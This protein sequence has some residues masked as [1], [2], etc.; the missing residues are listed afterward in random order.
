MKTNSE[1]LGV[2]DFVTIA[3]LTVVE[4][5]IYFV[6]GMP[7]GSTPLSWIFCLGIQAIPLGIIFMLM[8]TKVNKKWTVLISGLLLAALLLMSLWITALCVAIA[9]VIG[10][11]IWH[12]FDRKKFT[13]MMISYSLIMLG[14]YIGAFAPLILMKEMYLA[15]L[16]TMADFYSQVFDLVSGPLFFVALAET[17]VGS[18]IGSFLGKAVL[19]KHFKKAGIV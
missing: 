7:L 15:A 14:W 12:K 13:T 9:A 3:I 5:A 8:Y 4:L 6:I 18:V 10:E 17:V 16:P 2:R 11:I 19:K 1:K